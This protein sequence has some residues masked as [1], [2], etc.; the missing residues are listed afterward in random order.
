MYRACMTKTSLVVLLLVVGCFVGAAALSSAFRPAEGAGLGLRLASWWAVVA[1]TLFAVTGIER[2]PL[3]S[4]GL[5]SVGLGT[6]GWG[7]AVFVCAFLLAGVV[8][9]LLMPAL[10]LEQDAGQAAR[11]A[12]RPIALQLMLFAT[13]AVVEELV[14]RAVVISRLAPLSPTLAVAASIL[15]FTLPH[16][17]SWK[18]AQLVFVAPLG[19]VFALFFLWRGDLPACILAHFLV[20]TA[21]FLLLRLPR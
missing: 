15:L 3:A 12:A 13:A 11:I 1:A 14:C 9:R 4:V 19:A 21:G 18:P 17:F 2:L 8:A 16:L 20:D 6:I 5:Q 10:G 7:A